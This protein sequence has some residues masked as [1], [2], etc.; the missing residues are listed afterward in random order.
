[1]VEITGAD[2]STVAAGR[3]LI[4]SSERQKRLKQKGA[5]V[6]ITGLHGSG[7]N[8]LAYKLEHELFDRGAVT[9][10]INGSVVRSGLSRELDYSPPDRAEHLRR[11][12]HLCHMLND[13]GLITICTFI[14][15]DEDVRWQVAEIVGRKRFHLAYVDADLDLCKAQ[16]PELY[17][18]VE[19]GELQFLPG[20]DIVI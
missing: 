18:K 20:V 9:V 8:E 7:K 5:T 19:S 6:W 17:A 14:S 1:M 4:S 16:E 13:Q 12:A 3:S 10:V 2:T 15:P 11:V